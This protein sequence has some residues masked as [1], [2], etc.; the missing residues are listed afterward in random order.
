ML[1][2]AGATP[3][4]SSRIVMGAGRWTAAYWPVG[5]GALVALAL[6]ARLALA[7]PAIR[8]RWSQATL[9]APVAGSLRR[10]LRT[11]QL[12]R[13]L[14]DLLSS[15]VSLPAAL[16]LSRD[17]LDDAAFRNALDSAIPDV[18]AGRGLAA[19]LSDGRALSPLA[20]QLI[21]V[22]EESGRLPAMLLKAADILDDEGQRALDRAVAMLTPTLTLVMGALIALIVSSILFALFNINEL[23]IRRP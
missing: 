3:P 14:G 23:A 13:L 6:A 4:L 5:L 21:R 10:K 16:R 11:A 1:A 17:A 18:E 20:L 19:P 8:L 15:G 2:E 7:N 22:G 9:S 12:T